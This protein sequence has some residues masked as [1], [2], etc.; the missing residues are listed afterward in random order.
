MIACEIDLTSTTFSNTTIPSYEIE[1]TPFVNK[2][3]FNL[4]EDEEFTIPYVTD[5][6]QNSLDVHQLPTKAEQN[7]RI[8]DINEEDPNTY[9][10]ALDELNHHQTPHG[11][12]KVNISLCRSKR[13]QR[14]YIEDICSRFYQV[15]IVV[16]HLEFC[17][18]MKNPTPK[19]ISEALKGPKRQFCKEYLFVQYDKKKNVILL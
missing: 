17:L 14:I 18:P 4:L 5:T 10:D 15:R 11:E 19:K 3:G 1:L 2:I 12:S 7:L 6:I 8:M 16:S 13:Y 9:Q